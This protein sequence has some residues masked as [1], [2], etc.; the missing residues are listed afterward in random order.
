MSKQADGVYASLSCG[1][2]IAAEGRAKAHGNEQHCADEQYRWLT[3]L[4]FDSKELDKLGAM[5]SG[6]NLFEAMGMVRQEIRHSHFLGTLLNP[7]ENHGLGTR[8][9]ESLFSRLLYGLAEL[10]SDAISLLD[11]DLCDYDDLQVLRE[12]DYIDLLLVSEQNRQL[13]VIENKIDA[14]EHCEQ[15]ARYEQTVARR[16]PEYRKVFVFLTLDG[17]DASREGWLSLGYPQVI[18][19]L[20]E[21]M[22]D[23]GHQIPTAASIAIEHY[24]TLFKRYFMEDTEIA[25]LCRRIYK[26]HQKALDLIFEHRP[27]ATNGN[28]ARQQLLADLLSPYLAEHGWQEDISTA[29]FARYACLSWDA[30]KPQ[31]QSS[32]W[33]KTGRVILFEFALSAKKIQLKL[34]IG[35]SADQA[36]RQEIYGLAVGEQRWTALYS[37]KISLTREYTTI[38]SRT[39]V[40]HVEL[41]SMDEQQLQDSIAASLADFFEQDWP[42][43]H[44]VLTPGML[45]S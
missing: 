33:T 22:T 44:D 11:I 19:C 34:I 28:Q 41:D 16:Y 3:E 23:Y 26:K 42:V 1:D 9:F 6:F 25:Q 4:I 31:M 24:I 5:V 40:S 18:A 15:L 27:Q 21:L 8:F 14:G 32:S 35:P 36:F 17:S 12:Q 45:S 30:R 38:Y 7:R 2:H 43:I 39:I 29:S 20:T 13:F 10:E 37:R